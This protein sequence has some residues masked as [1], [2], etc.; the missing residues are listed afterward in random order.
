MDKPEFCYDMHR[1]PV[2]L[3]DQIGLCKLINSST[4]LLGRAAELKKLSVDTSESGIQSNR[5]EAL[6]FF[7]LICTQTLQ[8]FF[9]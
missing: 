4:E 1:G 9:Y 5:M 2:G 7:E 8:T 3:R 6:F